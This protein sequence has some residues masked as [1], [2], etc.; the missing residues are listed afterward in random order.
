MRTALRIARIAARSAPAAP[1]PALRVAAVGVPIQSAPVGLSSVRG[2]STTFPTLKKGGK[3]EAKK[4]DNK[5]ADKGGKKKKG[6]EEE[7][8]AKLTDAEIDDIVEKARAK[9]VKS[10]DW[11]KSVMFEGV[12]RG[13][14][15]VSPCE[16]GLRWTFVPKKC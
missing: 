14:G 5:K 8:E 10:A 9:M 7:A 12:E 15:R 6:E 2:F 3:K 4:A 1:R 13:R 11:A 16:C